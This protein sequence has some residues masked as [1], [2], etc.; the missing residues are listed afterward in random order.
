MLYNREFISSDFGRRVVAEMNGIGDLDNVFYVLG[1]SPLLAALRLNG[2][3]VSGARIQQYEQNGGHCNHRDS[4]N[5][6]P[7]LEP[8]PLNDP[9]YTCA[10]GRGYEAGT[11]Y[12]T[13][14][15]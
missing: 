13:F 7:N 3:V 8:Q 6:D 4:V 9:A 11:I 15:F 14:L 2:A 1:L 10:G 12:A 5:P